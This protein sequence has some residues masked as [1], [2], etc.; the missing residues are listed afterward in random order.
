MLRVTPLVMLLLVMLVPGSVAGTPPPPISTAPAAA[1][2]PTQPV[3]TQTVDTAQ[4]RTLSPTEK[5]TLESVLETQKSVMEALTWATGI[6]T[7][8][9]VVTAFVL[10]AFVGKSMKEVS[11]KQKEELEIRS[12]EIEKRIQSI[13]PLI[14][15]KILQVAAQQA[16]ESESTFETLR[17][18][19]QEAA[20]EAAEWSK[21]TAQYKSLGLLSDEVN[22]IRQTVEENDYEGAYLILQQI[23]D[24]MTS[25]QTTHQMDV[26]MPL[27][28]QSERT[29]ALLAIDRLLAGAKKGMVSANLL[30]NGSAIAGRLS[31]GVAE[32]ALVE[33]AVRLQPAATIYQVR[34]LRHLVGY[35]PEEV[36]ESMERLRALVRD[37]KSEN[38]ELIYS[39]AWNVAEQTRDYAG[40]I[41]ALSEAYELSQSDKSRTFT[42]YGHV[43]LAQAHARRGHAGWK[44]QTKRHLELANMCMANESPIATW[45]HSSRVEGGRL[46]RRVFGADAPGPDGEGTEAVLKDIMAKM[47]ASGAG[48]SSRGEGG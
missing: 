26:N 4:T 10:I 39:E 6:V 27:F 41:A 24:E 37:A 9:V 7:G 48:P 25:R 44:D 1:Q 2:S 29:K 28:D 36:G 13:E 35:K 23:E 18:T 17:R 19:A 43:I 8:I 47:M 12:R 30:Y 40:L 3:Q 5:S 11:E 46:E 21:R 31:L 14:E 38:C 42:S 22:A 33:E 34:K 15:G 16:K 45:Y 20:A 32:L